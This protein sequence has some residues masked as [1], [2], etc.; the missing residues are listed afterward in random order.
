MS[1]R[2]ISIHFHPLQWSTPQQR[3]VCSFTC[4]PMPFEALGR[5]TPHRR[6]W[7][8][9][10][11]TPFS[12]SSLTVLRRSNKSFLARVLPWRLQPHLGRLVIHV[13]V[14]PP[15]HPHSLTDTEKAVSAN[16]KA[17]GEIG[18][19][20]KKKKKTQNSPCLPVR[21]CSIRT[22]NNGEK[23]DHSVEHDP[24]WAISNQFRDTSSSPLLSPPSSVYICVA[25]ST[26]LRILWQGC[27]FN[28]NVSK[29]LGRKKFSFAF[30][31][32]IKLKR[33][34]PQEIYFWCWVL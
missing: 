8:H 14:P 33:K 18:N 7:V 6:S 23:E 10:Y 25:L 17:V 11:E 22:E 9:L 3:R 31:S 15:E 21:S 12:V 13:G 26:P 29:W 20:I 27:H 5:R 1:F 2:G 30:N 28:L 34:F 32:K 16:D 24:F 4:I 19:Y